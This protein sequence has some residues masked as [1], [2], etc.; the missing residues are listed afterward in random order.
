M[1]MYPNYRYQATRPAETGKRF[2]FSRHQAYQTTCPRAPP[3]CVVSL[4]LASTCGVIAS[5]LA[6]VKW[7]NARESQRIGGGTTTEAIVARATAQPGSNAPLRRSV[8]ILPR[9]AHKSAV[10]GLVLCGATPCFVEPIRHLDSGVSLGIGMAALNAALAE[11]G[12]EAS[13]G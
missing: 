7:H 1:G 9:D 10:H 4:M 11:Y 8:V 5:I 12:D 3:N 13:E 2:F 6:C